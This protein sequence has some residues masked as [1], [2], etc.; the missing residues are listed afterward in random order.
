MD[1]VEKCDS[2]NGL[3]P[4]SRF[5]LIANH[6]VNLMEEI[7]SLR[8]EVEAFRESRLADSILLQNNTIIQEDLIVMKGEIRKSNHKLMSENVGRHSLM[9]STIKTSIFFAGNESADHDHQLEVH[10]REKELVIE[11][12]S[13]SP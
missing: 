9:L 4:S 11:A 3:P 2:Y 10:D 6:V 13:D 1:P 7:S 8:K 12:V 5:E